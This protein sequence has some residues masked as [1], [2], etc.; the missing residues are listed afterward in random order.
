MQRRLKVFGK[1]I[2]PSPPTVSASTFVDEPCSEE[3]K[4]VAQLLEED[5]C[6][7]ILTG[8]LSKALIQLDVFVLPSAIVFKVPVQ[9]FEKQ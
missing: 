2:F 8:S 6:G 5:D 3:H 1:A 7:K 9:L 4:V